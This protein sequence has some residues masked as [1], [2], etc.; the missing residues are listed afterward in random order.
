MRRIA[1]ARRR[2]GSSA[3]ARGARGLE[4]RRGHRRACRRRRDLSRHRVVD[5]DHLRATSFGA[6]GADLVRVVVR[7]LCVA[8]NTIG[9]ACNG[10]TIYWVFLEKVSG[11][12][13]SRP[14]SAASSPY[15][16]SLDRPIPLMRSSASG[17]RRLVLGDQL[18]RGVGEDHEGRH[19]LLVGALLAPLAEPLEQLLVVGRR[20]VVAA[21]ALL[22]GARWPAACR[23]RGSWRPC[24]CARSACSARAA[25][26]GSSRSRNRDGLRVPRPPGLRASAQDSAE[27]DAGRGSCRR[28]AAGAPP[29]SRPAPRRR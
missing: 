9:R 23:T 29:R 19:A 4:R 3:T 7:G 2:P 13:L 16:S 15:R 25:S 14:A 18:Q 6:S 26:S 5:V 27:V 28:R 20:A 8:G 1:G 17:G 22:L 12:R 21:A 24:G 10:Q 11:S